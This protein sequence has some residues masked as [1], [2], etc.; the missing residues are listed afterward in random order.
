MKTLHVVGPFQA[1]FIYGHC[2]QDE[3]LPSF[4]SAEEGDVLG[5]LEQLAVDYCS[6]SVV[7]LSRNAKLKICPRGKILSVKDVL[8]WPIIGGRGSD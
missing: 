2:R 3:E 7:Y 8:K 6:P 5:T 1:V 4:S